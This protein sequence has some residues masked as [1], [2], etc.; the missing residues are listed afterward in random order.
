MLQPS[1]LRLIGRTPLLKVELE[2]VELFLKL[3][4]FNPGGSIK[5]R[6][7]LAIVED[8]EARGLLGNGKVVLE[9]TSG[10][11]GIG[12]ALVCAVKGYPCTI[13]M[14]ENM[15][16]ERRKLISAFG[17][18]VLLTPAE[19]GME[20][21]VRKVEDMLKESPELYFHANQ[22][23][24]PANPR[25]H[26]E[27]TAVEILEELPVYPELFVAG[28]GTGGTFTGIARRFK[29]LDSKVMC[30]AVEPDTSP[31]ISGG[32]PGPHLI[33]GIGAG[34]IPE[35]FDAHLADAV[36]PVSYSEAK[37]FTRLLA[38]RF[39]VLAGISSGAN[40]AVAVRVARK[41]GLKSAVTVLPDTGERYL[42]TALFD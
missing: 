41:L 9:A 17:A 16:V 26:Y 32:K 28:V 8:A 35:N 27:T 40:V 30:V 21:A 6:V 14:P 25:V 38:R 34:F 5:D 31:V 19:Q 36:E 13:V 7:A 42:S 24:N 10:N 12:L 11:T 33:Q 4:M 2:G 1:I 39:G 20:G 23:A 29:E 18:K 3:E 37:K 15:S 22:F